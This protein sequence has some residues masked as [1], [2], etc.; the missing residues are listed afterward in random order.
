MGKEY[1]IKSYKAKSKRMLLLSLS[2]VDM[3]DIISSELDSDK[4]AWY[5]DRL[6]KAKADPKNCV[7]C[8][9]WKIEDKKT[10]EHI[11]WF[12]FDGPVNNYTISVNVTINEDKRR[13]GYGFEAVKAMAQYAGMNNA[14]C[15]LVDATV[16]DSDEIAIRF[17]NKLKFVHLGTMDGRT[18]YGL[19]RKF[20]PQAASYM[21]FGMLIGLC[22]TSS[23]GNSGIG[24]IMGVA[25]GY[26]IGLSVDKQ[27]RK[28]Y[29][30]S[31]NELRT[32]YGLALITEED[33]K[34]RKVSFHEAADALDETVVASD[35]KEEF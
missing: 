25:I 9:P 8:L 17:L 10:H 3:Q 30:N 4:L 29:V 32:R 31:I 23:A 1:K 35:D 20:V 27:N 11:G 28:L 24:I 15:L 22:A 2:E 13:L 18:H 6:A 34:K 12:H 26:L 16:S 14:K 5:Q 7:Y 21:S 33:V 19:F